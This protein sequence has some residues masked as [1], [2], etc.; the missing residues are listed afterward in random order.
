MC[1][2]NKK[3]KYYFR[4]AY[5]IEIIQQISVTFCKYYDNMFEIMCLDPVICII[6]IIYKWNQ[7]SQLLVV[8]SRINRKVL[9]MQNMYFD[10]F[11]KSYVM[12]IFMIFKTS[13][14]IHSRIKKKWK[15]SL[16]MEILQVTC[17][18][19]LWVIKFQSWQ[20]NRRYL[21]FVSSST[22]YINPK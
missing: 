17:I 10:V 12:S 5:P 22:R 19:R 11:P 9:G 15:K 1:Q 18:I 14:Y 4:I 21:I 8:I 20:W 6:D 13:Y 16:K 7:W 2:V 3:C